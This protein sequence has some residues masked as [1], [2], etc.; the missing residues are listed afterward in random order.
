MAA[1]TQT[2]LITQLDA[3]L[4]VRQNINTMG[5]RMRVQCVGNHTIPLSGA[6]DGDIHKMLRLNSSDCVRAIHVFSDGNDG[7]IE[8]HLGLYQTAANG[9]AVVDADFFS[10]SVPLDTAHTTA[11]VNYAIG[12]VIDETNLHQRLWEQLGLSADP[13]VPY[14]VCFTTTATVP[15]TGDTVCG[16]EIWYT[17]G[18]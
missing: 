5:G 11:M 14:D 4:L 13:M 10:A 2:T 6:A 18:D 3:A 15:T 16:L 7:T 17:A 12:N 9:A 8:C 1:P